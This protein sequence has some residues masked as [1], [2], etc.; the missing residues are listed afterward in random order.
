M[1]PFL[2]VAVSPGRLRVSLDINLAV[3]WQ[4]EFADDGGELPCLD[5]NMLFAPRLSSL[6]QGHLH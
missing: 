4:P 2:H 1:V 3:E 6:C 5:F